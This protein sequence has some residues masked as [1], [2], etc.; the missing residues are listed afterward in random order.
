MVNLLNKFSLASVWKGTD[1]SAKK[2][3]GYTNQSG[4]FSDTIIFNIYLD[5]PKQLARVTS[6]HHLKV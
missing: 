4:L 6:T 1:Q 3:G 5:N 2:G